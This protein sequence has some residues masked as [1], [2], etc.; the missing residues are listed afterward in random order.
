MDIRTNEVMVL[1]AVLGAGHF[2]FSFSN[3]LLSILPLGDVYLRQ[4]RIIAVKSFFAE[5]PQLLIEHRVI[6]FPQRL[7]LN[8]GAAGSSL[9]PDLGIPC[10]R[11]ALANLRWLIKALIATLG[12]IKLP[13]LPAHLNGT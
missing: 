12:E 9:G 4:R 11:N 2:T 13:D 7:D 3:E 10:S 6:L 1:S 5:H 8:H